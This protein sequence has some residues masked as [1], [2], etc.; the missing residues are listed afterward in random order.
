[1][2]V[3]Y[4]VV[5]AFIFGTFASEQQGTTVPLLVSLPG[6]GA[7]NYL[8]SWPLPKKESCNR[9]I[10]LSLESPDCQKTSMKWALEHP[11]SFS[12]IPYVSSSKSPASA[13]ALSASA[14]CPEPLRLKDLDKDS[15]NALMD[16]FLYTSASL[17]LQDAI[18]KGYDSTHTLYVTCAP[19][20]NSYVLSSVGLL[21]F[22]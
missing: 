17:S 5:T 9:L 8:S 2:L 19:V 14:A 18:A 3:T 7:E 1:M 22:L 15:D 13:L 6:L 10:L 12:W 20:S 21:V 11:K 16:G 4:V